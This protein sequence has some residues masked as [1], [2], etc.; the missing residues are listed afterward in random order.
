VA[1]AASRVAACDAGWTATRENI[2]THGGMGFTWEMDC[3]LFYRRARLQALAL[4]SAR[5]WKRRLVGA[6]GARESLATPT[7]IAA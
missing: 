4:G 7:D 1:A 5:E 3:H 2:Q 6:L